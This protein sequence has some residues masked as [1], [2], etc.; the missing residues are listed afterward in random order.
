MLRE[1]QLLP[2]YVNIRPTGSGLVLRQGCI[3]NR[4]AYLSAENNGEDEDL[5]KLHTRTGRPLGDMSFV[6][7]LETITGE[8]LAHKKP[9]RK[10]VNR[11]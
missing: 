11:K 2:K 1:I 7:M 4:E 10:P 6:H 3:D 8:E 9:G 5:V